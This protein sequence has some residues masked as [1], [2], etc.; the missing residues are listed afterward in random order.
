MCIR[1]RLY[2][3]PMAIDIYEGK[4]VV[5][6]KVEM[7]K[8]KQTF[9]FDVDQKVTNVVVDSEHMLLA[10]IFDDKPIQWWT[11]QIDGPLYMDAKKALENVSEQDLTKV[12]EKAL[13]HSY[14]GIRELAIAKL[15]QEPKKKAI[16]KKVYDLAQNDKSTKVRAQAVSY[17]S[18]IENI[19]QYYNCLLYTSP[20]PRDLSTSRMP[21]SA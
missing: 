4:N 7:N 20:S 1:D 12:A 18:K 15:E 17:L 11:Q 19:D 9:V 2:R 3:L 8:K 10:E 6:Y 13:S 5:R 16:T 21:S 14:W